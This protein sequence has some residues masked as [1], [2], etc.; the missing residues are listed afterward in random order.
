MLITQDIVL[1]ATIGATI[2][3]AAA[4]VVAILL[5]PFP[6]SE[7]LLVVAAPMALI[8]TMLFVLVGA[9]LERQTL[10]SP[11]VEVRGRAL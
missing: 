1:I 9:S 8:A 6:I 5:E 10:D 11:N 3:I 4:M 2:G 7:K